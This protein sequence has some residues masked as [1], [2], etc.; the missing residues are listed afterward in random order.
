MSN[1]FYHDDSRFIDTLEGG[2]IFDLVRHYIA[3]GR[4]IFSLILYIFSNV[5]LHITELYIIRIIIIT[6]ILINSFL[7]IDIV[8]EN[9]VDITLA[10]LIGFG[11]IFIYT[12][13]SSIIW[14]VVSGV[15]FSSFFA[16][17]STKEK[18][19]NIS[20]YLLL[21]SLFTYPAASSL[22]LIPTVI[23]LIKNKVIDYRRLFIYI[24]SCFIYI[25]IMYII[26]W[27][28]EKYHFYGINNP[29]DHTEFM[30]AYDLNFKINQIIDEIIPFN[31]ALLVYKSW[32]FTIFFII[33]P[34]VYFSRKIGLI[35]LVKVFV[36]FL[37]LNITTIAAKTGLVTFR[38]VYPGLLCTLIINMYM[39]YEIFSRKIVYY[40]STFLIIIMTI[41]ALFNGYKVVFNLS[42]L[43][44]K[45]KLIV[46]NEFKEKNL[47]ISC[48]S[49][50]NYYMKS[51]TNGEA[52]MAGL[53][54]YFWREENRAIVLD[55]MAYYE[56]KKNITI[57][58]SE[59]V[60]INN[61][62][63]NTSVCKN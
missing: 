55:E 20:L 39:Y 58:K 9:G 21:L 30:I 5:S 50:N 41:T 31:S 18:Y 11:S 57:L 17:I 47:Y 43:Y 27:A 22:Y 54:D 6:F 52:K 26:I 3:L 16:L 7:I 35:F 25:L 62:I 15:I 38:T 2:T 44:E 36:L 12:N 51:F 1:F 14:I 42:N 59:I 4:P 33:L 48:D 29:K 8:K 53:F 61:V 49:D 13:I 63:Y 40:V 19:K 23:K 34:L 32:E 24:I 10:N 46:N 45:N 28:I 56:N 60:K 37:M